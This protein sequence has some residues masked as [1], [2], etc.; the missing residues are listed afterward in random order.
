MVF[1]P[2]PGRNVYERPVYSH[3]DWQGVS[4]YSPGVVQGA[5][6]MPTPMVAWAMQIAGIGDMATPYLLWSGEGELSWDGETWTGT[7]FETPEGDKG[8]LVAVSEVTNEAGVPSRRAQISV[9][10]P[11]AAVREMLEYDVGPVSVSIH[12]LYSDDGGVTWKATP[13]Q[14][15]GHLS[16]PQFAGGVYTVEIETWSGDADRGQPKMW[17]DE[18]QTAEHPG[19]K[20]FEFMRSLSEGVDA[21]WPP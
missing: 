18:T 11:P 12:G 19:D 3:L 4:R 21:R 9:A 7:T 1:A 14:L 13:F 16:R 8:A 6:D 15:F 17:S 2:A 10:V 20:G 5:H